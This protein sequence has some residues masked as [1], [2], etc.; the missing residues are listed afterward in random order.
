[1]TDF[2]PNDMEGVYAT[3][4]KD[5]RPAFKV[6]T[7]RAPALNSISYHGANSAYYRMGDGGKWEKLWE[8]S[9]STANDCEV[10]HA[11]LTYGGHSMWLKGDDGRIPER[12]RR[13]RVCSTCA[14][15]L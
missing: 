5:R 14:A 9:P 15:N 11:P 13:V 10:C 6:Y 8:G 12:P 1:M 3:Y 2:D 7:S 4:V